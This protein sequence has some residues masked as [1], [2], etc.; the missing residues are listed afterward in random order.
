MRTIA[1]LSLVLA[2]AGCGDAAGPGDTR[3]IAISAGAFHTCAIDTAHKAYCWGRNEYGALGDGTNE[4]RTIPTAVAGN[5]RFDSIS[6]GYEYT[7]ALTAN[8]SAWCWGLNGGGQLGD[9][10][11]TNRTRP[12]RVWQDPLFRTLSAGEAHTCGV[13]QSGT[14]FC[15]GAALG[16][17]LD[18][19]VPDDA[20]A[21]YTLGGPAFTQVSSGFEIACA[22]TAAGA[23]YCW[24]DFA[25][26]IVLPDTARHS[27]DAPWPVS[28]AP[29][30]AFVQIGAGT[31]HACGLTAAGR[32]WCWG[33]NVS[34][35][36]GDGTTGPSQVPHEVLGDH[37]F[38]TLHARSPST[39]CALT[40]AG[41]A[42]C[43]GGVVGN[44]SGVF[45]PVPV[46]VAGGL[47][48]KVISPG[49]THACGITI[50]G[51]AWCWGNGALGELG[52]GTLDN[53]LIPI[54]I[55][56]PH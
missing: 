53:S 55:G 13:A 47:R 49:F 28:A 44:G 18:M 6:A 48:F 24:G 26:G 40:G 15:W 9:N 2:L 4:G 20:A 11:T 29:A 21:P 36:L 51:A 30:P 43:W 19:T 42:W 14:S 35:Q 52:T 33:R 3:W 5:L 22:L 10:T 31:K 17:R 25:P 54:V 32:A 56:S 8:G 50:D 46:A 45:S 27:I 23:P 16:P 41:E 12:V 39:A 38:A 1:T 7:C 34:G 37:V